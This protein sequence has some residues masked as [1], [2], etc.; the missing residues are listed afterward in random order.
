[1]ARRL[2]YS[3][4]LAVSETG[5]LPPLGFDEVPGA[6]RVAVLHVVAEATR[7]EI[8][9][10]DFSRSL[11]SALVEHLGV[12]QDPAWAFGL[13]DAQLPEFLDV[14]ELVC[15]EATRERPYQR[16]VSRGGGFELRTFHRAVLPAF[17][18]KF[19]ELS[20]R[21]RFGYHLVGDEIQRLGSPA[22]V[23]VVVGPAVLAAEREG[24]DQVE[25][26][27]R[28]ALHHQRGGPDENDDALT[29]AGAA[30]EAALKA[31]GLDGNT[32]GQLSKAF[33]ASPLAAPQ[34]N[35]V[36]EM[37]QG[38]LERTSALRNIH[39]DAHGR[40]PGDHPDVPQELVDLAVHLT[41]AFIVYLER[42]TR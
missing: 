13:R 12:N 34:L 29:A 22:L 40:A 16:H 36:P 26:S 30:L 1:M 24:W 19:N 2:R 11:H 18:E 5:A 33:R 4:R 7:D 35:G 25:R 41:G 6:L 10:A 38:L 15:E 39:G 32:L 17:A 3:E 42:A 23:D 27:Y 31:A 28:E 14:I 20:D 9:G 37:L 21:H 8:V